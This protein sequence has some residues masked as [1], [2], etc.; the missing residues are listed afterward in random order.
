MTSLTCK[1]D[2]STKAMSSCLSTFSIWVASICSRSSTNFLGHHWN[3]AALYQQQTGQETSEPSSRQMS[4]ND[5]QFSVVWFQR[6]RPSSIWLLQRTLGWK[7]VSGWHASFSI[8]FFP[9]LIHYYLIHV[10]REQSELWCKTQIL[11]SNFFFILF[12]FVLWLTIEGFKF[13]KENILEKW[14]LN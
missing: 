11:I 7:E 5:L 2:V 6:A 13:Y 14:N 1:A 12:E 9:F 8:T 4:W 3:S 10:R